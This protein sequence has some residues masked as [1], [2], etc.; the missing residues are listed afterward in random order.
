MRKKIVAVLLGVSCLV[1]GFILAYTPAE[2]TKTLENFSQLDSIIEEH[3]ISSGIK[4]TQVQTNSIQVD[5]VLTRKKYRVKV[6]PGFSK[7]TF[8]FKLHQSLT[9]FE[10]ESPAKV[11]LPDQNMTIY[12]SY[13]NTV[14]RTAELITDTKIS[15]SSTSST[16]DGK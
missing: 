7:T 6:P 15:S 16:T 2:T 13:K 1:S 11:H 5:S 12:L 8:H 9:G 14:I 3:I 10:I 4:S